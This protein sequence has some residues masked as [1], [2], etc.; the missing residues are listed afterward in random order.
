MQRE[1][2]ELANAA[3]QL[4][5]SHEYYVAKNVP[6]DHDTDK[7]TVTLYYEDVHDIYTCF[8]D[9]E[10]RIL[11]LQELLKR[12]IKLTDKSYGVQIN[13]VKE[14]SALINAIALIKSNDHS[15]QK[16]KNR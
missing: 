14:Q 8:L 7:K 11:E 4:V 6:Q 2:I 16:S 10:K 9:Y 15:V 13:G 1:R 5:K 3:A 12:E